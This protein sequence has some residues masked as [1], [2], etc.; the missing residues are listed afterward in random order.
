MGKSH[1]KDL[2]GEG[3]GKLWLREREDWYLVYA[4]FEKHFKKKK[5]CLH[6]EQTMVSKNGT[7]MK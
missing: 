1:F 3:G 4:Q 6:S 2:K 5:K 7:E